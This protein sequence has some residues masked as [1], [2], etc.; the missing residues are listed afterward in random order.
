MKYTEAVDLKGKALNAITTIS[1][2]SNLLKI[3]LDKMSDFDGAAGEA[4]AKLESINAQLAE[5]K[6]QLEDAQA[7]RVAVERETKEIKESNLSQGKEYLEKAKKTNEESQDAL[8]S[9]R[10]REIDFLASVEAFEAKKKDFEARNAK[11]LEL[12]KGS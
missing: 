6:K 8:A 11:I 10:K 3:K 9:I 7:K 5:A 2:F 4:G 12:A 1:E